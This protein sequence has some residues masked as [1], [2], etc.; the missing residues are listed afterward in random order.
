MST[1]PGEAKLPT[2]EYERRRVFLESLKGLTKSE[3]ME[4]V[5]LLQKHQV[6]YSENH[7]GIFL[8]LTSLIQEVFD[9]LEQFLHFTQKNRQNLSDRDSLLSTLLVQSSPDI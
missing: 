4:I 8:N 6:T 1:T 5:R 2:E 9:D 3:Y 7:N